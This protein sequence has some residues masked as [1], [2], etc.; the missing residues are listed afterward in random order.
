MAQK[1]LALDLGQSSIGWVLRNTD[2]EGEQQYSKY[3]VFNFNK[4]VGEEKNNEYSLAAERTKHRSAR[5]LYQSRK[6]KL[7]NTLKK[8]K[9]KDF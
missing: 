4:G 3:G 1:I 6:Y 7:W 5:R 2:F 8:L 9:A